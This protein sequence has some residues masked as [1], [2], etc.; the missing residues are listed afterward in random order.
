MP[1]APSVRLPALPAAAAGLADIGS[2]LLR[3][4]PVGVGL[5]LGDALGDALGEP[6]LV[7][8]A[9]CVG[10]GDCVIFEMGEQLGEGEGLA[11]PGEVLAGAIHPALGLTECAWALGSLPA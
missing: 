6:V 3:E 2:G 11:E 4:V 9:L 7:G 5:L 8:L 10:A 1:T